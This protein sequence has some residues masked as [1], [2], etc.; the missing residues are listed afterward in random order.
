MEITGKLF[1]SRPV[2]SEFHSFEAQIETFLSRR[3]LH[4]I[5]RWELLVLSSGE[6]ALTSSPQLNSASPIPQ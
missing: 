4:D 1:W 5:P 3:K 6:E 2:R